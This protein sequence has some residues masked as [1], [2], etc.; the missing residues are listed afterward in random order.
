MQNSSANGWWALAL[1][2]VLCGLGLS[3]WR[4]L[5]V[6][7]LGISTDADLVVRTASHQ[8][9]GNDP[10]LS[11][12]RGDR[13]TALAGH[14][15]RSLADVMSLVRNLNQVTANGAPT[16]TEY[17]AVRP[18]YRFTL[19]L[20]GTALEP[21]SL[22]PGIE[23]TDK[24][25][26]V[27]GRALPGKVGPEGLKSI[28]AS[29]P[30]AVLGF[31]R[32]NAVFTGSVPLID[33]PIQS[34]HYVVYAI[35]LVLIGV[36][37]RF[38][39]RKIHPLFAAAVG[40]E[41]AILGGSG[42][43]VL[44][45]QWVEA[46]LVLLAM[47]VLGF[48][49]PRPIAFIGR[50]HVDDDTGLVGPS[51]AL[52][53]AF[54]SASVVVGLTARGV[55]NAE[56]A[57]QFAA[58]IGFLFIVY[59]LVAG[60]SRRSTP[61]L[62]HERGIFLTGV[63]VLSMVAG[64]FAY[65][66]NPVAFLEQQW[67]PFSATVLGLMWFGDVILSVHGP[68]TSGLEEVLSPEARQARILDY[69]DVVAAETGPAKFRLVLF[70]EERSIA[71]G[72]GLTGFEVSATDQALH[73]ALSILVREGAQVPSGDPRHD[74]PLVGIAETMQICLATRLALPDSGVE[75]PKLVVILVGFSQPRP[76]ERVTPAPITATEV[77]HKAMSPT[78]WASA[79]LE[80]LPFISGESTPKPAE[81]SIS[82]QTVDELRAQVEQLE[83]DNEALSEEVDELR[84]TIRVLGRHTH[85]PL[86]PGLLEAELIEAMTYLLQSKEPVVLGGPMGAGKEFVAR[87]STG[88]D[89]R[90]PGP[91]VVI[92][93]ADLV[94]EQ[95]FSEV[96]DLPD[97]VIQAVSGGTLL[98]RSAR[99]L[100]AHQVKALMHRCHDHARLYFLIDDDKAE[101][102][103]VLEG[104]PEDLRVALEHREVILPPFRH[105]RT[106]LAA[107]VQYLVERAALR[108]QK[109]I[110]GIAAEA[111]RELETFPFPGHIAQCVVMVNVAVERAAGDILEVNDFPGL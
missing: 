8:V 45:P 29:R 14:Q 48:I 64:L 77:A 94:D 59:E 87:A 18:L 110:M 72:L 66:S 19:T 97:D 22:P 33:G 9:T 36:I 57:L 25:V 35:L 96:D 79:L 63:I 50:S 109:E 71:L 76:G 26:E 90:Y 23:P 92:D 28:V 40:V 55:L 53:L 95:G 3:S 7:D 32:E 10:Q 16:R 5:D 46:D 20:R 102:R 13:I 56:S 111:M 30:E 43:L 34:G 67:I 73:D 42:I 74:D 44:R 61:D 52:G 106:I 60:F 38:R 11:V 100:D 54:V 107:V 62:G 31:E 89:V 91:M 41:T 85:Q 17:Q 80:G 69:F 75:I 15:V 12:T 78:I 47:V 104:Y 84:H 68:A 27:D 81:P 99:L 105:R 93:A 6:A 21:G 98:V 37:W 24:L 83:H 101:Q 51:V 82:P 2:L 70:T 103:S 4:L 65:L 88:F 1:T 86:V 108:S 49:L 58:V 39:A